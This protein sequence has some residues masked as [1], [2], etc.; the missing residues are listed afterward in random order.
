MYCRFTSSFSKEELD[1]A[2]EILSSCLDIL[3]KTSFLTKNFRFAEG[4][5]ISNGGR[6]LGP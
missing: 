6:L 4:V 3:L 2:N 5:E 1:F